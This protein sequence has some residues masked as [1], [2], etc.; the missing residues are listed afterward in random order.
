MAT[1]PALT[2][3]ERSV[4]K[5]LAEDGP[6]KDLPRPLRGRLALYFLVSET[7]QGWIITEDGRDAIG[8]APTKESPQERQ[9]A[10]DL[11]Q[12]GKSPATGKRRH[13]QRKSPFW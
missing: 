3:E 9:T 5:K 10:R 6:S 1:L 7:P 4:L 8:R 11:E 2:K 12:S 13:L